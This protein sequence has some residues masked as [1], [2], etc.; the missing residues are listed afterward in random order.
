MARHG[1]NNDGGRV[2]VEMMTTMMM[3]M[4][5]MMMIWMMDEEDEEGEEDDDVQQL[6][7]RQGINSTTVMIETGIDYD[8]LGSAL[9]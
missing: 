7:M 1:D 5:M 8:L 6:T 4:M 3:M 9:F 2:P